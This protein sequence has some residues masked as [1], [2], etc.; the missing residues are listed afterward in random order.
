MSRKRYRP[1]RGA[2]H[3]IRWQSEYGGMKVEQVKRLEK[4]GSSR[5]CHRIRSSV[6]QAPQLAEDVLKVLRAN[7][8][9]GGDEACDDPLSVALNPALR[10]LSSRL[11]NLVH[12]HL[13]SSEKLQR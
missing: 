4:L 10:L 11:A 8:P 2:V 1:E 6:H 5:L 13:E 12:G 9:I 7:F 3:P